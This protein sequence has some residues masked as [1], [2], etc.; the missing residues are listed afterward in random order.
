M[1]EAQQQVSVFIQ[2]VAM[3]G[4]A[5]LEAMNGESHSWSILEVYGVYLIPVMASYLEVT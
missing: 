2:D 5:M 3:V 1:C 4:D